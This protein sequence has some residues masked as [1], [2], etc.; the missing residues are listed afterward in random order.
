MASKK[1][2]HKEIINT[3]KTG[4]FYMECPNTNEDVS[5]K[6]LHL[7]DND[8]FTE[9]A[10]DIYQ[11][12]LEDIKLTKERLKKIKMIGATRSETS[13]HSINIGKIFERLAPTLNTFRFSHGDCRPIFDPIDYVIFEGLTK[14]G[15]VEKIF[16]TDIK[17]GNASLTK[18][19]KEI[20]NII[21]AKKVNFKK[22]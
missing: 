15:S 2:K 20:K 18:R 6:I 7:F 13:A 9:E 4:N 21:E 19:Q 11:Q 22:Y 14:K 8:N 12:Q 17:T 16:F 3:L 10:V 1:S 5:V